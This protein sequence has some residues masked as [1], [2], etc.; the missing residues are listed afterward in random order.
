VRM[1]G[2]NLINGITLNSDSVL[3]NLDFVQFPLKP[4]EGLSGAP[5]NNV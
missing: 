4:E 2:S 3:T 1:S 5:G